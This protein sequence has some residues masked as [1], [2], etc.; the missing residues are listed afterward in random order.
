M[1]TYEIDGSDTAFAFSNDSFE[2]RKNDL[3]R[4]GLL[5]FRDETGLYRA[6]VSDLADERGQLHHQIEGAKIKRIGQ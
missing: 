2:F 1:L 4:T 5:E 3:G 6:D